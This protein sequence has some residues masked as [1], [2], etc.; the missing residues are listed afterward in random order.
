MTF[1][2]HSHD[3]HPHDQ[4]P[5]APD[6]LHRVWMPEDFAATHIAARAA[7]E[8]EYPTP[9]VVIDLFTRARLA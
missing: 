8:P 4:H 5:G 6:P 1:D 9:G 7:F 3:H 2:D